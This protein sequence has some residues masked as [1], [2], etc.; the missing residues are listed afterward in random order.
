MK[1][2]LS[3]TDFS[4]AAEN[5]CN[6]AAA[7]AVQLECELLIFHCYVPPTSISEIPLT[8]DMDEA[9]AGLER[10]LVAESARLKKLFPELKSV[11]TKMRM[12]F[13]TEELKNTIKEFEPELV[14]MG[15]HGMSGLEKFLFGSQSIHAMREIDTPL[16]I[17]PPDDQ[18]EKINSLAVAVDFSDLRKTFPAEKLKTFLRLVGLNKIFV[19]NSGP[20]DKFDPEIVFGTQLIGQLMEPFQTE[21]Y[22]ISADKKELEE[23]ILNFIRENAISILMVVPRHLSFFEKIT[24]HSESKQLAWH[25]VV[26]LLSMHK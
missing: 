17:I 5:A 16:M 7:M 10:N 25:T 11:K 20:A 3:A 14:V 15:R 19:I 6:Y 21:I 22:F 18:Y 24:H 26:P 8:V 4:E 23:S 13:V 1:T 12:G 9:S 2:I